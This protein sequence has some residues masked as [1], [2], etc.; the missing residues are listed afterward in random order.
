MDDYHVVSIFWA[1]LSITPRA[2][3]VTS[4]RLGVGHCFHL[5]PHAIT[6][7]HSQS[8]WQNL[9]HRCG[10]PMLFDLN[11]TLTTSA[12]YLH[13]FSVLIFVF[14]SRLRLGSVHSH[15]CVP[16]TYPSIPCS[17]DDFRKDA[18]SMRRPQRGSLFPAV[19]S[20]AV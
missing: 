14:S 12:S 20:S 8:T 5:T 13:L 1:T 4:T 19:G 15:H 7:L 9:H 10:I 17:D 6:E 3:L 11:Q 18:T 2:A 16:K